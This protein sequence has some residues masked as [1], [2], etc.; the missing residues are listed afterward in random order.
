MPYGSLFSYNTIYM[1]TAQQLQ[2][3][4]NTYFSELTIV[5]PPQ[6]L[7]KPIDYVLSMG[8]KRIRPVLM[9][10]AYN[11]YKEDISRIYAPSAGLEIFHNYTLLHDDLMDKADM[12][13][14]NKTV[15]KVW[16]DNTAILS[17]D[18]ML[19]LAYKYMAD[20]PPEYL[21]IIIDLFNT[22][23]LEICEGQQYDV[24]YEQRLDV[25][26]E[27]YLEMIRLKTA[28]LLAAGLKM[29]AILGGSTSE[30]ANLL[31]DFGINI[32]LA[33]QLK[34]DFLD[35]YGDPAVFGKRI[36]GDILCNKK[37]YMLIKALELADESQKTELMN[38]MELKTFDPEEKI[39]Q[40][41]ALYNK[42]G[43]NVICEKKMNE[44]Y[45]EAINCLNKVAV[46]GERKKELINLVQNLMYREK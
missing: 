15:H 43:I 8:G 24:E 30:D 3:K 1:F 35:V 20:C 23:A 28:V 31:Y 39:K 16:D 32:G 21:K 33:F 46:P 26:E 10:M 5:K 19:V 13:R 7:Y 44:Y 11:L 45:S 2:E 34:D 38:W 6:E 42:V 29:G 27:E 14:G 17:G 41:I 22:T 12:R 37:T 40:F 25:K 4:I 36:G 18:A 9:L